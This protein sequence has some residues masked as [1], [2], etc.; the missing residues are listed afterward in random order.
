MIQT[1]DNGSQFADP[2]SNESEDGPLGHHRTREEVVA[3]NHQG[4]SP[5]ARGGT[6]L[7]LSAEDAGRL[8]VRW[9]VEQR[10]LQHLRGVFPRGVDPTPVI[11]L[12]RLTGAG[13][14]EPIARVSLSDAELLS[15]G[16]VGFDV[17][18]GG[19][20]VQ[21]ELG[22]ETP[23]GGWLLLVRSNPISASAGSISTPPDVVPLDLDSLRFE[24]ALAATGADLVPVFP[25]VRVGAALQGMGAPP[26]SPL[27]PGSATVV[28]A[29]P[30]SLASDLA[31]HLSVSDAAE[32]GAKP[33]SAV[34]GPASAPA[35]V[36]EVHGQQAGVVSGGAPASASARDGT[37]LPAG[38]PR[39][40]SYGISDPRYGAGGEGIEVHTELLVYGKAK[41]GSEI[42]LFGHRIQVGSGGRFSL[43]LPVSNSALLQQALDQGL[44]LAVRRRPEG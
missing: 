9:H 36:G 13:P 23:A 38:R 30:E 41:P 4:A 33:D 28:E 40:S 29:D 37:A 14:G 32:P 35:D 39:S 25:E 34:A 1:N 18:G 10:D 31:T 5:L 2:E 16:Q 7:V 20:S 12:I 8:A 43:H 42:D 3:G 21:A 44:P 19:F 17:C 6:R 11:Q 27:A 15:A 22:L 24:P 26:A